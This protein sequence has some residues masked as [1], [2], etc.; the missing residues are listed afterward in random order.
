[1]KNNEMRNG[2]LA[3]GVAKSSKAKNGGSRHQWR[4]KYRKRKVSAENNVGNQWPAISVSVH[5]EMNIGIS[6]TSASGVSRAQNKRIETAA[7]KRVGEN[8]VGGGE[9]KRRRG[10][11][12]K[13]H[14]DRMAL[15]LIG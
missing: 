6:V 1:V 12:V 3:G 11:N 15:R 10:I 7:G 4:R 8:G 9:S 5:Q 14:G 13:W 2:V